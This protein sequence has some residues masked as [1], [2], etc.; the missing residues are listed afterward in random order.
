GRAADPVRG[1]ELGDGVRPARGALPPAIS[2]LPFGAAPA[3]RRFLNH[4]DAAAKV[5]KDP[6]SAG[7]VNPKWETEG[8]SVSDLVKHM[9][10]YKLQFGPVTRGNEEAYI[11]VHQGLSGYLFALQQNEPKKKLG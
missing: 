8:T 9:S 11:A 5:L 3:A 6:K 10:K 7:L 1:T 4:L 2:S